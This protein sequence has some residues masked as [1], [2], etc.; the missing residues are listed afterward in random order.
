MNTLLEAQLYL[1]A[2][3]NIGVHPASWDGKPRNEYQTGWRDLEN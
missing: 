1:C 3:E 2:I